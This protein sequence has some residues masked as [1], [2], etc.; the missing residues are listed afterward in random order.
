MFAIPSMSV[1]EHEMDLPL[2]DGRSFRSARTGAFLLF[3]DAEER[4]DARPA[5]TDPHWIELA[6]DE[7][8]YSDLHRPA[9]DRRSFGACTGLGSHCLSLL[10]ASR[11]SIDFFHGLRLA[12]SS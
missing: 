5:S 12:C 10:Q 8:R 6:N 9:L 2:H 1:V 3:L 7:L 11:N 4:D